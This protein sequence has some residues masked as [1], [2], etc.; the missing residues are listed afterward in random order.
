M[1]HGEINKELG[2]PSDYTN[3]VEGFMRALGLLNR[4]LKKML[5]FV[6]ETTTSLT[7]ALCPL[8]SMTSRY[9]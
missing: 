6:V 1:K 5:N 9:L 7:F 2:L 8:K 3:T 4:L